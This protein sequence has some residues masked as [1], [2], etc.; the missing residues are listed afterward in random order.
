MEQLGD[1][2][3]HFMQTNTFAPIPTVTEICK[4]AILRGCPPRD[5][6][7]QPENPR[8]HPIPEGRDAASTLAA[9]TPGSVVIW[10]L[11]EP[12]FLLCEARPHWCFPDADAWCRAPPAADPRPAHGQTEAAAAG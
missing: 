6:E 5:V 10:T 11:A 12:R 7:R 2:L 3:L 1:T 9:A 4:R 8:V